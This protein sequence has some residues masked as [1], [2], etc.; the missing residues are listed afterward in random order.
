MFYEL[1]RLTDLP[2]TWL[3]LQELGYNTYHMKS[4]MQKPRRRRN[5]DAPWPQRLGAVDA[6]DDHGADVQPTRDAAGMDRPEMFRKG[7][8][9]V[10]AGVWR[11]V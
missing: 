7:E 1:W 3:A 4:I 9:Y 10:P 2:A 5:V 6:E 11:A 8:L